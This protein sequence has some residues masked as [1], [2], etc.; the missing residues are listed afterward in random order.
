MAK[1]GMVK[2][3]LRKNNFTGGRVALRAWDICE[4]N[5][6]EWAPERRWGVREALGRERGVGVRERRWGGVGG[7]GAVARAR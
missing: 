3:I 5:G 2:L 6:G 1:K 7:R 4:E